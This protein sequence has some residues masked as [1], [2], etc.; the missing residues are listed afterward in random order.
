MRS[1]DAPRVGF[2]IFVGVGFVIFVG[3]G[4]DRLLD[5]M[6]WMS[7]LLSVSRRITFEMNLML[8]IIDSRFVTNACTVAYG[9]C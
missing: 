8:S 3:V 6:D 4:I 1:A 7:K 9:S 2:V 5:V